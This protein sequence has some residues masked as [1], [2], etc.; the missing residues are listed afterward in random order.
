MELASGAFEKLSKTAGGTF[1]GGISALIKE[2]LESSLVPSAMRG[3]SEKTT[4]Y[5]PRGRLS[6]A[7]KYAGSLI[8]AF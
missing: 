4:S 6:L 5:D 2:A 7:T 1:M 3:Y 8:L